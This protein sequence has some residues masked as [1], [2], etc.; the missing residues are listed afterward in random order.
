MKP[1]VVYA[2]DPLGGLPGTMAAKAV[3]AQLVY[4]EHDSPSELQSSRAILW[5]QRLAARLADAIVFPN[6]A[7]AEAT[8]RSTGFDRTKL[9]IAWNVPRLDE[10]CDKLAK[11]EGPTVLYYHG[12]I[13]P[14]RLPEQV[15]DAASR[16][17]S[18]LKIQIVGYEA[19]SARGYISHLR[20]RWGTRLSI[21][22]LGTASRRAILELAARADIGLALYAL[23]TENINIRHLLGASVKSFDYMACGLPVLVPDLPDWKEAFVQPGY[24]LACDPQSVD[25]LEGALRTLV[26]SPAVRAEMGRRGRDRIS[27]EWHY[28]RVFSPILTAIGDSAR[29]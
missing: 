23:E 3:G 8:H 14:S 26:E 28:E 21:E 17:N 7:R 29:R 12:S 18:Q 11:P 22:Y 16:L 9:H 27:S 10:V 24:A 13:S 5:S 6:A 20:E 15:L 25:S 2:S 1:A 19:P 4:H